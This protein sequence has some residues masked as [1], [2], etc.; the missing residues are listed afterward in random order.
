MRGAPKRK[1]W[2]SRAERLSYETEHNRLQREH[3]AAAITGILRPTPED[4]QRTAFR[5]A[6]ANYGHS[7]LWG[8]GAPRPYPSR[9]PVR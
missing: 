4:W 8:L 7:R 5:W 6:W 9:F 2:R 3:H 1:R